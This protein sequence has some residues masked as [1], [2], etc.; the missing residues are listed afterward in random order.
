MWWSCGV[1][2]A[3][4][5]F[6]RQSDTLTVSAYCLAADLWCVLNRARCKKVHISVGAPCG[7]DMGHAIDLYLDSWLNLDTSPSLLLHD[8]M[9]LIMRLFARCSA[10]FPPFFFYSAARHHPSIVWR[11][12][13]ALCIF[14]L[15]LRKNLHKQ[16]YGNKS[17]FIWWRWFYHFSNQ[18]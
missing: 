13:G 15:T 1:P 11:S 9:W 3:S 4:T 17:L 18:S 16:C 5:G 2:F 14:S 8:I 6:W 7:W 10:F 12:R